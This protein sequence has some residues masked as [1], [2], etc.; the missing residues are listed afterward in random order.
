MALSL[1]PEGGGNGAN[2]VPLKEGTDAGVTLE[3]DLVRQTSEVE[4]DAI[5][6]TR[7]QRRLQRGAESVPFAAHGASGTSG[8]RQVSGP[9][10]GTQS[11]EGGVPRRQL[12]Q[13]FAQVAMCEVTAVRRAPAASG[14]GRRGRRRRGVL[15]IVD[16]ELPCG[17]HG[18]E[19]ALFRA[20]R[21]PGAVR[22][23]GGQPLQEAIR[24]HGALRQRHESQRGGAPRSRREREQ[25]QHGRGRRRGSADGGGL[26]ENDRL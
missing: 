23:R 3:A 7:D 22:R 8:H 10:D 20:A 16:S 12:A 11:V 18:V 13:H 17:K 9:W 21:I 15:H 5:Q 4:R 26:P 2:H 1:E 6:S 19:H 14:G 24:V 25:P